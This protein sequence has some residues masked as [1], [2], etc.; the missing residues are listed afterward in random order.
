MAP[1]STRKHRLSDVGTSDNSQ[2]VETKRQRS[3]STHGQQRTMS[4]FLSNGQ[5]VVEN[6]DKTSTTTKESTDCQSSVESR[7][8]NLQD[9]LKTKL[10]SL[11][12]KFDSLENKI[13]VSELKLSAQFIEQIERLR[14]E[15]FELQGENDR[16]KVKVEEQEELIEDMQD[17]IKSLKK[18]IERERELRN[19]LEQ[20]QRRDSVRFLGV[21][22]EGKET[23]KQCEEKVLDIIHNVLGLDYI[24][25]SDISVAHRVGVRESKPRPIIVKFVTRKHKYEVIGKRRLLKGTK[26]GII[27]DLTPLNMSRLFSAKNHPDVKNAWTKEGVVHVALENGRILKLR[28]GSLLAIEEIA[29]R[30]KPDMAMSIPSSHKSPSPRRQY[31]RKQPQTGNY[32]TS[33]PKTLINRPSSRQPVTSTDDCPNSG[34]HAVDANHR[35]SSSQRAVGADRRPLSSQRAAGADHHSSSSQRAAAAHRHPGSSQRAPDTNQRSYS[36]QRATG[37]NQHTGSSQS[38]KNA[39][40]HSGSSLGT[41]GADLCPESSQSTDN[42]VGSSGPSHCTASANH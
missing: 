16:L 20:Y 1:K 9:T 10:D 36:S 35:I 18:E 33:T 39:D 12:Q 23:P 13:E 34:Q 30:A 11:H 38:T 14:G 41:A 2:E 29:G 4:G 21:P 17:D 7:L 15:I 19:D 28:G 8:S 6:A 5:S 22:D 31:N 32:V 27:E 37:A 3:V 25:H 24:Q 42:A 26:K 40:G